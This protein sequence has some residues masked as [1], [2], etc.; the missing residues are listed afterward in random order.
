M[1]EICQIFDSFIRSRFVLE[2]DCVYRRIADHIIN[3]DAY[4]RLFVLASDRRTVL[5]QQT[6]Q[7]KTVNIPGRDLFQDIVHFVGRVDHHKVACFADCLFNTAHD[8]RDEGILKNIRRFINPG[9]H[10]ESYNF[11]FILGQISSIDIRYVIVLYES[12]FNAFNC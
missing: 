10:C 9:L 3:I 6:E 5:A 1:A 4:D 8:L 12:F 2:P 7:K 11:G